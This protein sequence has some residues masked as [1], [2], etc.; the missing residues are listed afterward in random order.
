[1]LET[2]LTVPS[3]RV[4]PVAHAKVIVMLEVMVPVEY[5]GV[6]AWADGWLVTYTAYAVPLVYV[7][8]NVWVLFVVNVRVSP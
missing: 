8:V 4:A 3:G 5:V 2:P 1:M 6:Q 7:L